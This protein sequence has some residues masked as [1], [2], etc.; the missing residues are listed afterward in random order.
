MALLN[1]ILAPKKT[2]ERERLLHLTAVHEL[3]LHGARHDARIMVTEP[4]LDIEGFD[5]TISSD[6]ESIY[7]QS[8]GTLNRGGAR[9]WNIRAAILNPSFYNRDLMP[10]LDGTPLC[11]YAIG[12]TG[13]VLIHV[14]DLDAA[15]EERFVVNYC[16]L[17]VFWLIGVASGVAGR[18]GRARARAL[19]LLRQIRNA[20]EIQLIRLRFSDFAKLISVTSVAKFRLHV[21]NPSNW[22]SACHTHNDLAMAAAPNDA[23][24]HLWA[25]VRAEL[26]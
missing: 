23:A 24:M 26:C 17:D 5:F 22:A 14:I 18:D 8:K 7:I 20:N 15:N 16:Y 6:F 11:N 21:G 1:L 3:K 2:V 19:D 25:A 13:G 10:I 9:S 12:A 4:E